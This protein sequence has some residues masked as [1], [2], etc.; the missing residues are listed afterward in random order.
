MKARSHGGGLSSS[1]RASTFM[2]MLNVLSI[3]SGIIAL[4]LAIPA[5]LPLLGWAN[6]II[7]PIAVLG[8]ALGAMSS[9]TTGRNLN[10]VVIAV[11]TLRLW[12]GGGI[13]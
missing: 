4:V 13:L 9:R 8:L 5:F 3:L 7:I 1:T 12:L 6:W 10:I 2:R 11:C